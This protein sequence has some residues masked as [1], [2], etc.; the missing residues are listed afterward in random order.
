MKNEKDRELKGKVKADSLTDR[1]L[2]RCE[3]KKVRMG[4]LRP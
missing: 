1:Q 4:R 3:C 2:T